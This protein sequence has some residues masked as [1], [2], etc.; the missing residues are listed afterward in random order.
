MT[1]PQRYACRACNRTDLSLTANGRVRSHAANGKRPGLDNPACPGGSDLPRAVETDDFGQ[2]LR[3]CF[4]C[5]RVGCTGCRPVTAS[6]GPNP[7]RSPLPDH[8]HRY[9]Y[10]DDDNG[11]S[12]SFCSVCGDPEPDHVHNYLHWDTEDGEVLACIVCR[13]L[14]PEPDLPHDRNTDTAEEPWTTS[15]PPTPTPSNLSKTPG[16]DQVPSSSPVT[17]ANAQSVTEQSGRTT[18]SGPTA[19]AASR[20]RTALMTDTQA[21]VF[22]SA[23]AAQ[24][25]PK[26]DWWGRYLLP[27]PA[28]GKR[29]AWTRATTFCKSIS[30]TFALAKWA[31]RMT[32][33]G[34]SMRPDLVALAHMLDVKQDKDKLNS[35]AE[36]AKDAAGQKVSANLGVAVHTFTERV[37]G[38]ESLENVPPAH[39]AD[40]SAYL[41]AMKDAG[42]TAVPH[43]I[44][45]ITIVPQFDV[46][47][48]FDRVLR[49]SDGDYVIG[50]VKTGRTLEYGWP[51]I[52]IQLA[53]YAQGVNQAGVWDMQGETWQ[54]APRVRT[55]YGIVMHLPVGE[56]KCTLYRV[57]LVQGWAA[58]TLCASVRD[59]RKT[60]NLAQP[61]VVAEEDAPTGVGG[62]VKPMA[63]RP[64]TWAERFGAVSSRGDASA[65]YRE[66]V[67]EFGAGSAELVGLVKIGLDKLATLEERAG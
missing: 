56:A 10:M 65:L 36:Q 30:D 29:Q 32:V 11:H 19:K 28:T 43:L 4:H 14:K 35:L 23:P 24:P 41:A 55:D 53:L 13:D 57:D 31:E 6:G 7:H 50:D 62:Y 33:K 16:P 3:D 9:E 63:V 18:S 40:V 37:D 52:A 67:A 60:R 51:E 45:R 54:Q 49:T 20:T 61:Y 21:D 44:E 27:H 48:T 22:E 2:P 66:A 38:G 64:P 39:R 26:R 34:L 42:L 15:T 12:G 58:A 59:W 46:A 47:G 8:V 25:E 17:T 5:D 1:E